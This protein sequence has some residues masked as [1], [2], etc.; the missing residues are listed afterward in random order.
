MRR[1]ET[2]LIS[3]A[4][5]LLLAILLSGCAGKK[6]GRATESVHRGRYDILILNGTVIDGTGNTPFTA[7]IGIDGDKIRRI[8]NLSGSSACRVIDATGLFVM[9]G[10]IDVHNH[11]DAELLEMPDAPNL[12]RQGITTVVTGNCGGSAYPV[13]EFFSALEEKGSALNVVH[14]IGHN[15][16]RRE[17]MGMEARAPTEEELA[18]MKELVRLGME[19]GAVGLSTGLKYVPG[20]WASTD[21]V[22]E[23]AKIVSEF[24]G[25]YATHMRDEGRGVV[26]SVRESIEIGRRAKVQV[27]IS[28][29]KVA[30]TD[31][32]GASAETLALVDKARRGGVDVYADLYPYPATSTGLTVL[33]QPWSLEG[34]TEALLARLSDSE[35]RAK[36]AEGII[37]NIEHDRG[38]GDPSNIRI[39]RCENRPEA[40]GKSIAE[41]LKI[42]GRETTPQEAAEL[43]MD[44]QAEGGAQAIYFCLADEDIERII[45]CPPSWSTPLYSS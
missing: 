17:V 9:P 31:C 15:T 14:L 13:G 19:E 35:E 16:I 28:H 36:I 23:L 40:E 32:W 1:H 3:A 12:V 4:G 43:I 30:S 10:I 6:S 33:F 44:I 29:H 45:D 26:D 25:L 8:G 5:F 39:A 41:L 24:H 22:V 34:G 18:E 27:Q 11:A 7:D 38:G 42:E 37:D 21:E 2:L 20:A